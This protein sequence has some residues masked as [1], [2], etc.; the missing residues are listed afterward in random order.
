MR[1]LSSSKLI[2]VLQKTIEQVQHTEGV[3]PDDPALLSLK[4]ILLKRIAEL[5][6]VKTERIPAAGLAPEPAPQDSTRHAAID[7]RRI[8]PPDIS[9]I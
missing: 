5:A 8:D 6:T 9:K 3:S 7:G 2:E 1:P 4:R